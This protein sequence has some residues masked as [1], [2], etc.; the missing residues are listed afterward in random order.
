MRGHSSGLVACSPRFRQRRV[1][2]I[3]KECRYLG[4]SSRRVKVRN[5]ASLPP[6]LG[7]N[8]H[9]WIRRIVTPE[10]VR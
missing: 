4:V 1:S 3:R 2:L 9:P 5:P 8:G 7:D 10:V 6:S